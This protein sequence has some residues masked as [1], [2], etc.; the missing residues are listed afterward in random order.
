MNVDILKILPHRYPFLMVDRILDWKKGKSIKALKNISFNEQFFL[1]HFPEKPIM[2]GVLIIEALAQSAG[3][4][5]FLSFREE[6][7]NYIAYL[8]GV[9]NMRFKRQVIPGDTLILEVRLKQS[10]RN[11]FKFD[12]VAKVNDD[13]VAGGEITLALGGEF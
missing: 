10:L 3:I 9:D 2:P 12:G 5:L 6:N 7:K 11:I 1:G 13:I 4:L 8:T